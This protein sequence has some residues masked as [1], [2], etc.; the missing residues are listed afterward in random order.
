M[1]VAITSSSN[2]Q[3]LATI[4]HAGLLRIW[5][6]M[7]RDFGC[8]L[9]TDFYLTKSLVISETSSRLGMSFQGGTVKVL[10]IPSGK[11]TLTIR[12]EGHCP[13]VFSPNSRHVAIEAKQAIVVHDFDS[14]YHT[15][16]AS[17]IWE[18]AA[19]ICS[20][21]TCAIRKLR[22]PFENRY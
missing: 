19:V 22:L 6:L 12:G 21:Q 4:L 17:L 16:V 5:D 18:E 1:V 20:W 10:D 15:N 8:V 14:D 3:Y 7:K 13:L 2:G 11:L 9:E